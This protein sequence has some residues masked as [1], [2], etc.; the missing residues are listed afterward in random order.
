[1]ELQQGIIRLIDDQGKAERIKN[2]PY[3]R[4]FASV[5]TYLMFVFIL[6]LPFGLLREYDKLGRGRFWKDIVF[7]LMFCF[8]QS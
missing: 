4:N 5:T 1:M 6:L 7:G 8:R 2:F 3:P